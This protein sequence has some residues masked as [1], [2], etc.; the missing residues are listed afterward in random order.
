M[1][2]TKKKNAIC[3]FEL[4]E[5]IKILSTKKHGEI[6]N[7]KKEFCQKM[8]DKYVLLRE[9]SV[10]AVF[11]HMDYLYLL[12]MG[13]KEPADID[14]CYKGILIDAKDKF[15]DME[16]SVVEDETSEIVIASN[17]DE[18]EKITLTDEEIESLL[19]FVGYGDFKETKIAFMG[20]EGGLG[21][22]SA[23]EN[24]DLIC[25]KYKSGTVNFLESDIWKRGYW[26]T[27][28]WT[29]GKKG[30]VPNSPF[31]YLSSRM[32]LALESGQEEISEWF[33]PGDIRKNM[34]VRKFLMEE[35]L[36]S[37]RKGI[38]TALIDWRPLPR[39]DE[40]TPLP[41]SNVKQDDYIAAFS[42]KKNAS[43]TYKEWVE[44]REGLIKELIY[45]FEI[46]LLLSFGGLDYKQKIFKKIYP[47]II[48]QSVILEPSGKEIIISKDKVGVNT[49]IIL[50]KF[51]SY[52]HFG[53]TGAHDLTRY[54]RENKLIDL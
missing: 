51:L 43:R 33:K 29:P 25:N 53:L 54:I 3:F 6:V 17:Y 46:P 27:G 49:T 37:N 44:K 10:E 35:G 8:L 14:K 21:G 9:H 32:I 28:E 26:K 38:K 30:D 15:Q 23:K 24:I 47:E 11:Q 42:F 36:Y 18:E 41:Y 4:K 22:K 1:G 13:E 40:K 45:K 7:F 34:Y 39:N 12:A 31:L 16:E 19:S 50:A 48:F 20:I 2:W 5:Y 52:E